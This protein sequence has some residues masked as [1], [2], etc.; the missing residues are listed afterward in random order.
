MLV[1]RRGHPHRGGAH[2]DEHPYA[3]IGALSVKWFQRVGD[4]RQRCGEADS[5]LQVLP[6]VEVA[7]VSGLQLADRKHFFALVMVIARHVEIV[8]GLSR[9][10]EAA[11]PRIA[12][13]K[14]QTRLE[15]KSTRRLSGL[16][17]PAPCKRAGPDAVF[18]TQAVVRGGSRQPCDVD[19]R[20]ITFTRFRLVQTPA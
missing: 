16:R 10:L 18:I 2:R 8:R 7:R 15:K 5:W 19:A 13:A 20:P 6:G 11:E 3:G 1:D 12:I 14:R 9:D 4:D 17:I